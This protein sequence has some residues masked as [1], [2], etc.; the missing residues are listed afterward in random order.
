MAGAIG[1][2]S[3]DT[4]G[5]E[6]LAGR[7]VRFDPGIL[8]YFAMK[9]RGKVASVFVEIILLSDNAYTY[10]VVSQRDVPEPT[11]LRHIGYGGGALIDTGIAQRAFV[12]SPDGDLI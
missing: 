12:V 9:D 8:L 2:L 3:R 10:Y 11:F 4:I 5:P 7:K 6:L 1:I